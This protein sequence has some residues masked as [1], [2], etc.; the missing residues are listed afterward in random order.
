MNLRY[1]PFSNKGCSK[2]Q[3]VHISARPLRGALSIFQICQF[4]EY[5]FGRIM[6]RLHMKM[7]MMCNKVCDGK[8]NVIRVQRK[9][10]LFPFK[11]L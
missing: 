3:T 5:G 8:K 9:N 10:L 2:K 6:K 11:E 7:H 1:F 4:S